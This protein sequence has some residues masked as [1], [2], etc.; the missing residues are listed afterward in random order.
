MKNL[1]APSILSADFMNLE[2][3][4]RMLGSAGADL[5]H[6]DVMDG[7]FVPNL[8]FGPPVIKQIKAI[9][10]LPLDVHLMITNPEAVLDQYIEA[11]ADWLSFQYEAAIHH[12]RALTH[13]RK[14]GVKA[15]IVLNPGT[16]VE[17]IRDLLPDCDYV[18]LMSV[19]PGFG[20]QRY[21]PQVDKKISALTVWRREMGLQELLIEVDGGVGLENIARLKEL[22]VNIFVAGSAIFH[23]PDPVKTMKEMKKGIQ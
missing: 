4:V 13:I 1:L 20:G 9:S 15:G 21:I 14:K 2:K 10:P 17:N 6:C 23:T 12:Q 19:N 8:T 22:G 18:L 5:V 16:A 7:H 3:E 11:G